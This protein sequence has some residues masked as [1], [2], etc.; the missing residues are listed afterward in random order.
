LPRVSEILN[1]FQE[2]YLVNWKIKMAKTDPKQ[3]TEEADALVIGSIVDELVQIDINNNRISEGFE[4]VYSKFSLT[5]DHKEKIQNCMAGW[6]KFKVDKP[7]L[8][9]KM[10]EYK[11]NMQKELVLGDLVGHPDFILDDE[12]CDLKTSK[13]VSKSHWMQTAQYAK[14]WNSQFPH[15][16]PYD[17]ADATC[18]ISILRLDKYNPGV[19][20]Y[21]YLEEPFI[22]FWQGKFEARY[23]AYKEDGEF[24]EMMRKKLEEERLA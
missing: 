19:Y 21:K 11:E 8:F 7:E 4:R 18:K 23:E 13:Q 16:N 12:V 3:L 5:E 14:M 17:C 10:V 2:P 9:E 6:D 1:Y 24:K 22:S 20:E 15:K